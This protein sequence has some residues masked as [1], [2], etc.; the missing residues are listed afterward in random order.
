MVAVLFVCLGNI[1][2]SPAAEGYL[3]HLAQKRAI[4]D[5]HIES[6]GLGSWHV[7]QLPDERMREA[8]QQRGIDLTSRGQLFDTVYLDV[9]DY[10]LAADNSVL[11]ELQLQA[12][13]PEQKKKIHLITEYSTRYKGQEV[14]DPYYHNGRAFDLVLDM[15]EDSCQGLLNHLASD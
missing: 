8:I 6:C 4:P 7:G 3:K 9:F 11:Y 12:K 2:R 5:L 10:I 1:C 14:P 13:T 15:I